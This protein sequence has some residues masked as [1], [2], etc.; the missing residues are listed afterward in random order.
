MSL[1]HGIDISKWQ[2]PSRIDY[3]EFA[4]EPDFIICRAAYGA[5]SDKHFRTHFARLREQ[6]EKRR[7]AGGAPLRLGAYTFIRQTQDWRAQHE[8][9]VGELE[10]VGFGHLDIAPVVDL[11]WNHTNGDG[12]IDHRRFNPIAQ[13]MLEELQQ[14]YGCA[15]PYLAPG[16]FQT[17]KGPD[18]LLSYHWWVAHHTSAKEPWLPWKAKLPQGD[19]A[20]WQYTDEGRKPG[21]SGGLD[22]NRANHLPLVETEPDEDTDDPIPK[23]AEQPGA[24]DEDDDGVVE[25]HEIAAV[26]E[27]AAKHVRG[28]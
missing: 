23:L 5:R 2:A 18:W 25:P 19:W 22:L 10:A 17:M 12:K 7:L 8:A 15:M 1:L 6:Q 14:H 28:L 11:E 21:Y 24:W 9:F 26:L 16:F 4:K 20:I 27:Q 13:N 3:D